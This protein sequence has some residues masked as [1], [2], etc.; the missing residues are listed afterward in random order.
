MLIEPRYW[1]WLC[2][3]QNKE[4]AQVINQP[5]WWKTSA[6]AVCG[7]LTKH[8]GT[9]EFCAQLCCCFAV[10]PR[11]FQ[12]LQLWHEQRDPNASDPFINRNK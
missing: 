12:H 10:A 6:V 5:C 11:Y 7:C 9:V 2:E 3:H 8:G 1:L 4:V